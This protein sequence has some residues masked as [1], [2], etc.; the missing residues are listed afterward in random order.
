VGDVCYSIQRAVNL[1]DDKK[2]L[3]K[4]IKK[5]MSTDHSWERVCL[6]YIEMYNLIINKK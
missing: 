1:Y 6:E 5:G 3:N 4:I 2:H